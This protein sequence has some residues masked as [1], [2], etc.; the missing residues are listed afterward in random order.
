MENWLSID[1]SRF[2]LKTK[3]NID[4]S[5]IENKIPDTKITEREGKKQ[6]LVV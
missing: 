6:V 2:A 1:S 5:E 3:Y 4:E